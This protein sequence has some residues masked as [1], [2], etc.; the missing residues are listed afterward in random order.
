MAEVILALDLPANDAR[1]LLDR[2]PDVRWV[3]VGAILFTD[4]GPG[5][6]RELVLRGLSVFL[7]LKWHDI[8][9]TVAGA[10]ASARDLGVAMATV[11]TAGGRAMLEAASKAAGDSVG[12]VGVTILTSHTA[13][14]YT[15]ATGR[16]T[17]DVLTEVGRLARLAFESGLRGVVCSPLEVAVVRSRAIPGGWIVTPGIRRSGDP[18]GDQAR[19]ATPGAAAGAGATHLVVGRPILG[20]GDPRSVFLEMARESA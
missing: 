6:V 11:H 15:S 9:N 17:V 3:K 18:A 20:A 10:V 2:V 19:T 14:S 16:E 12:I 8:P 1:R 5:L 4:E 13:E 7:D